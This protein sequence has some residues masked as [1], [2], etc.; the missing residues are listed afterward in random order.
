MDQPVSNRL[1]RRTFLK[2]SG[3]LAATWSLSTSVGD[4]G[5]E[6]KYSAPELSEMLGVVSASIS[7]QLSGRS[8]DRNFTL[9][10]L[11]NI[12]RSELDMRVIDLNTSSIPN[13]AKVERSYLDRLRAAAD[14]AGCVITNLKMNQRG[15][16]M[17]SRDQ[18][19]RKRALTEYKRSIDIAAQL[20]CRW[21]RPLPLL[22]KPDMAV[23]VESY[24]ELCDYGAERKVQLLVEN[25]GWMQSDADSVVQLVK[26][27]GRNVAAG[28]DTGNWNDNEIRYSALQKTFPLAATCDFKAKALG[29]MGQHAAY[30]LRRCFDIAWAS[31]FRGPWC[32]EHSNVDSKK[33]MVELAMLRDMLRKWISE[34]RSPD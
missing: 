9:L 4:A 14:K 6:Q 24:R 22:D 30:D 27:I 3:V 34:G 18:G 12:L 32:L 1:E 17:S 26:A 5:E 2:R 28:V 8:K 16:D 19:E 31:G 20:G 25:F 33:L 21:A 23:H 29:P 7:R 10:E 15:L 11:P 13:F